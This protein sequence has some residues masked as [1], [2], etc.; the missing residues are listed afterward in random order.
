MP[1]KGLLNL[2]HHKIIKLIHF[3]QFLIIK[4]VCGKHLLHVTLINLC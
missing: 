4:L 2:F 1:Q 3:D